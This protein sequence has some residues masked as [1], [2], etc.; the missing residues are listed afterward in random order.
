MTGSV[1]RKSF[2][3]HGGAGLAPLKLR[4]R[5]RSCEVAGRDTS[6]LL[7]HGGRRSEM[8]QLLPIPADRRLRRYIIPTTT[9]LQVP[10]QF[11]IVSRFS[12]CE[13]CVGVSRWSMSRTRTWLYGRKWVRRHLHTF[14]FSLLT[15]GPDQQCRTR[16][17]A[18]TARPV[19]H[20]RISRFGLPFHS[21][22]DLCR[23]EPHIRQTASVNDADNAQK[24]MATSRFVQRDVTACVKSE[25]FTDQL[26]YLSSGMAA[27]ESDYTA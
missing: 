8:P 4:V 24:R 5:S 15:A 17:M 18:V 20:K 9:A 11:V 14:L 22:L 3:R 16:V 10:R 12:A 7:R 21:V 13:P 19:S 2:L 26:A 6:L 1:G 25:G 23:A 27:H